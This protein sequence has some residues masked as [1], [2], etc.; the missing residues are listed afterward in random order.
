MKNGVLSRAGDGGISFISWHN[1]T[2]AQWGITEILRQ[3]LSFGFKPQAV[4]SG[5]P[6]PRMSEEVKRPRTKSKKG[7]PLSNPETVLR[8]ESC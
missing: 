3:R 6:G 7:K 1:L 5:P 8:T 2:C 4:S